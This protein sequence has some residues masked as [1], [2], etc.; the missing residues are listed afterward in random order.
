M[1]P[2]QR[3]VELVGDGSPDVVRLE[4]L[5]LA[6]SHSAA[7]PSAAGSGDWYAPSAG[8]PPDP[9]HVADHPHGVTDRPAR[10]PV[11]VARRS[12]GTS[13]TPAVP[14]GDH[15]QLD[16]EREAV[17]PRRP[18]RSRATSDRNALIPHCVSRYRPSTTRCV[19]QLIARPP[20]S[21]TRRARPPGSPCRR[22]GGCR[23]PCPS[24]PPPRR[25]QRDLLGRVGEVGVG[26]G[27][28][29][30]PWRRA[31]PARTAAPLPRLSRLHDDVLGAGGRRASAAWRPA[32]RRRPRRSR[33]HRPSTAGSSAAR[34]WS[35][36]AAM[37]PSSRYAG[38][39]TDSRT[40]RAPA[41]AGARHAVGADD[42]EEHAPVQHPADRAR[43]AQGDELGDRRVR[44]RW[45]TADDHEV[46]DRGEAKAART[47]VVG[48]SSHRRYGS[49]RNVIARGARLRQQR[50]GGQRREVGRPPAGR[51]PARS[52]TN[53][54]MSAR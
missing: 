16:V 49:P 54:P 42:G 13:V 48:R 51:R 33:A 17:D 39:T 9:E 32:T 38:I 25:G 52:G 47:K 22:G 5:G 45:Q 18:K 30:G 4:D 26:E 40:R 11:R 6:R 21:R 2:A 46:D 7:D 3:G 43:H 10:R 29:C 53:T 19:I 8:P 34:T 23:R 14:L 36:V 35:T 31:P 41:G 12:T 27:D 44:P 28:R 1:R 15:E 50:R 24:P 37:R 20:I